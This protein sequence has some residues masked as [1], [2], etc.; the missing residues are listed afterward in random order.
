MALGHSDCQGK[1]G[2]AGDLGGLAGL[3]TVWVTVSITG[4]D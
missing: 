3:G 4:R 2:Q 1:R